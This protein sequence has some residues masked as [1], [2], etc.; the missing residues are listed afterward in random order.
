MN[1][2]IRRT[3]EGDFAAI[4]ATINNA[5]EAYR[6]VIP[7]DRW[8]EPYMPGDELRQEISRGVEFWG[9]FDGNR[10][11]G[12]MGIQDKR[13]VSLIRHAYTT[14]ALQGKGVGTSLLHHVQSLT[15]KPMLI[16]TWAAAS[17]AIAFYQKNGF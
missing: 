10:L 7:A 13:D 17:W 14:T 3:E 16:G 5:A 9:M 1:A 4:L 12:V 11:R 6:G 15:S 2:Q 8:R